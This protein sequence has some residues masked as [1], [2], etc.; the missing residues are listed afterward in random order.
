MSIYQRTLEDF[1]E[2][3]IAFAVLTILGQSCL[4]SVAAMFVLKNGTSLAQITELA[5]VVLFTMGVNTAILSQQKPKIVFNLLIW[6]VIIST[7]L[8]IINTL[9]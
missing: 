8:I 7:V 3:Y 6:S 2:K 1:K 9:L 5:F 4:G